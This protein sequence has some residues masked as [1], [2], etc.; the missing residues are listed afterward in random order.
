MMQVNKLQ[1]RYVLITKTLFFLFKD[2]GLVTNKNNKEINF[3]FI[4]LLIVQEKY[5]RHFL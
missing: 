2:L 5:F 1:T 3:V 4:R